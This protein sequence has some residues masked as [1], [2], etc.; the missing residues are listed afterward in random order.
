[1]DAWHI[2]IRF[3]SN[4][5]NTRRA[6]PLVSPSASDLADGHPVLLARFADPFAVPY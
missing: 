2:G 5:K 1:M 3:D 6:H 4:G